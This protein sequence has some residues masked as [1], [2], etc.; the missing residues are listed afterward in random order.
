MV[1]TDVRLVVDFYDHV[2]IAPGEEPV[3]RL[4]NGANH[5]RFVFQSFVLAKIKDPEDDHHPELIRTV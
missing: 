4:V 2:T 3:D 5:G 1:V